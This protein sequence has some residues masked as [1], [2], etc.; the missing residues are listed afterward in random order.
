MAAHASPHV[1]AVHP[2]ECL[3]PCEHKRGEEIKAT[4]VAKDLHHVLAYGLCAENEGV[5]TS[6]PYY[7]RFG[8]DIRNK[9]GVRLVPVDTDHQNFFDEG[10]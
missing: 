5:L 7:E 6:S 2:N 3:A 1:F 9:A 10:F 4:A 8:I